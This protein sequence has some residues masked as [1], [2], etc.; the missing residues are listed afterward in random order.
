MFFEEVTVRG[1]SMQRFTYIGDQVEQPVADWYDRLSG[2][3]G[4]DRVDD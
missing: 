2:Y 1:R 3:R 4:A